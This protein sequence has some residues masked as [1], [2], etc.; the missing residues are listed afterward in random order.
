LQD[1]PKFEGM[2]CLEFQHHLQFASEFNIERIIKIGLH[3]SK[4]W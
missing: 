3:L 1:F 2:Q 4:L